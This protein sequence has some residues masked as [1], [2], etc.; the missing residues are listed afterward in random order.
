MT[1]FIISIACIVAALVGYRAYLREKS[2]AEFL[3]VPAPPPVEVDHQKV[4][5]DRLQEIA[6]FE[7]KVSETIKEQPVAVE[8]PVEEQPK[9]DTPESV[10]EESKPKEKK[11]KRYYHPKKVQSKIKAK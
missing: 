1:V 11:K 3:E 4:I 2:A 5:Q 9:A 7:A 6:K 10:A 8:L